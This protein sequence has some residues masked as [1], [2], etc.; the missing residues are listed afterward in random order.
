MGYLE[1]IEQYETKNEQEK[2]DQSLMLEQMEL[3]GEQIL[4]RESETAHMTSS[5][6]VLN[7]TMD[8]M[9]MIHHKLYNTWAWTGG[10]ADGEDDPLETAIREAQEETGVEIILPL[11]TEAA[12]IEVLPVFGHQKKG[13]YVSTHLHFNI[14]YILIAEESEVLQVNEEE[15]NGVEWVSVSKI[16]EYSNEPFFVELYQKIIARGQELANHGG[17]KS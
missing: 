9:L 13:A 7:P 10:H 12:S 4:T 17:L 6:V 3:V 8:K 2:R 16:P 15:T 5:G 14:S 11:S 1:I